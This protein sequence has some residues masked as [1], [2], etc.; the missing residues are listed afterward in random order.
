MEGNLLDTHTFLWYM[1]GDASISK[2]ARQII[3]GSPASNFIS[4]ASL[5]EV[6]IKISLG[7]LILHGSF[8]NF[9]ELIDDNGF[10]ILPIG[11]EDVLL[12]TELPFYHRD[13]FDRIIIAQAINNKLMLISKDSHF[14]HYEI[15]TSW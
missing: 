5:W 11:F 3:E 15:N 14:A 2:T 4:V 8:N 6:A 9:K 10:Q 13:P 12:I 1:F 7:K